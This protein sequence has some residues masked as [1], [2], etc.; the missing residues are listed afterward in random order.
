MQVHDTGQDYVLRSGE[1]TYSLDD[2]IGSFVS[3]AIRNHTGSSDWLSHDFILKK[4]LSINASK[5]VAC[6][7]FTALEM[8]SIGRAGI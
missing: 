3:G 6:S 1:K 2:Y 4:S 5:F 8:D 7:V